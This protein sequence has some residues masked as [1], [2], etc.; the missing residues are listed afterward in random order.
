MFTD[1]KG[2]A[3]EMGVYLSAVLAIPKHS[4]VQMVKYICFGVNVPCTPIKHIVLNAISTTHRP[5]HLS[6][7]KRKPSN[8][9]ENEWKWLN[10]IRLN[11]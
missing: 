6:A 4:D 7:S 9:K 1:P 11:Y 10:R 2:R 8:I 5:K 3:K